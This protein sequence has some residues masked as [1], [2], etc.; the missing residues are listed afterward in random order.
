M[1]E[2]A[3]NHETLF[4]EPEEQALSPVDQL[5]SQWNQQ[6]GAIL[7]IRQKNVIDQ[8][9][10]LLPYV[11]SA[12]LSGWKWP[13]AFAMQGLILMAVFSSFFNWYLTHSAGPIFQEI[14]A[15]Q[16]NTQLEVQRE[17]GIIDATEAE[18]RR[19]TKS[20]KETFNLHMSE[21]VLT[22]E[23]ALQ[24]LYASLEDSKKSVEQFKQQ[25]KDKEAELRATQNAV[26]IANSGTPLFFTI[27]LVLAAGG[28]R[29]GVQKDY[30]RGK[31]VRNA[32][33][34][35]LYF[36]TSQGIFFNLIFLAFLH[37]G[38]SGTSYGMGDFF[39]SVG[40]LVWVFFW[41]AFYALLLFYFV[42]VSRSMYQSISLRAPSSD[43]GPENRI[44]IRIHN[45]FLVTF[46]LFEGTFLAACYLLY[47]ADKRFF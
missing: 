13:Y 2:E 6:P 5:R 34:L 18:I 20:P 11:G 8:N 42:T 21:T 41:I 24:Q 12:G 36:A 44:L 29:R 26:A 9:P 1:A 37:F 32:A 30:P 28:I 4:A 15:N 25:M 35:Y 46:V 3:F 38:L 7:L 23:Q 17:Q 22:R 14:V 40:P 39:Q 27:A 16:A 19:I 33:D 43:W 47:H 45:N 10:T 31:Y